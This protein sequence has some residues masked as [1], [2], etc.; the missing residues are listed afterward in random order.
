M[1]ITARGARRKEPE[2]YAHLPGCGDGGDS[3][4]IDCLHIL[5]GQRGQHGSCDD[6]RPQ[7]LGLRTLKDDLC[8]L[9]H[10]LQAHS[11]L[12]AQIRQSAKLPWM[13]GLRTL[14]LG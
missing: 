9:L 5:R 1:P 13:M 12:Q 6:L 14:C 7:T 3:A 10:A 11:L 2:K 8:Q 4:L